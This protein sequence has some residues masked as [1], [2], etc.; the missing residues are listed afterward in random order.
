MIDG[1][2]VIN[3]DIQEVVDVVDDTE[4]LPGKALLHKLWSSP[5]FSAIVTH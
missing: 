5:A 1:S 4:F 3:P 2:P